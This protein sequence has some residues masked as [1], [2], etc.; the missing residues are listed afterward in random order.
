MTSHDL[1]PSYSK[2]KKPDFKWSRL[3][4]VLNPYVWQL[5]FSS[6]SV[7]GKRIHEESGEYGR[8]VDSVLQ[9]GYHFM[10]RS[11]HPSFREAATIG[12]KVG[13][14]V[15][16]PLSESDHH[17]IKVLSRAK[18]ADIIP[19]PD[20]D[21]LSEPQTGMTGEVDDM[22]LYMDTVY[23]PKEPEIFPS[24]WK[25]GMEEALR[26]GNPVVRSSVDS[27]THDEILNHLVYTST[28]YSLCSLFLPFVKI[29]VLYNPKLY[30][31][32]H[33]TNADDVSPNDH[34]MVYHG[35]H[36][37]A[38]ESIER[39]GFNRTAAISNA[40]V[41]GKGTYFAHQAAYSMHYKYSPVSE[42]NHKFLFLAL[43]AH[44]TTF[45]PDS[46]TT[47][48]SAGKTGLVQDKSTTI[49]ISYLDHQAYPAYLLDFDMTTAVD[50]CADVIAS[51]IPRARQLLAT[52]FQKSVDLAPLHYAATCMRDFK[53]KLPD[54]E[55]NVFMKPEQKEFDI[56]TMSLTVVSLLSICSLS[57]VNTVLERQG[58]MILTGSA[59]EAIISRWEEETLQVCFQCF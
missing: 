1:L 27:D 40:N 25:N 57:K 30:K 11:L 14:K 13:S 10:H 55:D 43:L 32:F 22:I 28:P 24:A 38:V 59:P 4:K 37:N 20:S 58:K 6:C 50:L 18:A 2:T 16:E 36:E 51:P 34:V 3:D 49:R 15:D 21:A 35:T 17:T 45:T 31:K 7:I 5:T 42:N 19:F 9:S 44:G 52:E 33:A 56:H 46:S 12:L 41:Y 48:C 26:N 29:S 8:W 54:T 47:L 39:N 53:C 23:E